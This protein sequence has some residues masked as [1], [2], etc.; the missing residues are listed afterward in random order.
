MKLFR[1]TASVALGGVLLLSPVRAQ[2]T[3]TQQQHEH[4]QTTPQK[5]GMMDHEKM[6]ADMKAADARLEALAQKMKS[7][8]GDQKISAMQDLLTQLVQDQIEMHRHMA[9]MHDMMPQMPRK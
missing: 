2:Q 4:A 1:I 6:M 7:A 9:M 5:S 3:A 8:Q